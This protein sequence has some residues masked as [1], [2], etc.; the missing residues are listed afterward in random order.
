MED[1]ADKELQGHALSAIFYGQLLTPIAA[2]YFSDRYGGKKGI[3]VGLGVM[4]FCT[5]LT[6][7]FIRT[8]SGFVYAVRVI[9]GMMSGIATPSIY[10]ILGDWTAPKER[11]TLISI[12]LSAEALASVLA[13]LLSGDLCQYG[14]SVL[15]YIPG[16]AGVFITIF[17]D[18][19]AIRIDSRKKS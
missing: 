6:P 10:K 1:W 19:I 4:S 2:G 12:V 5:I 9:Q 3:Y 17:G 15:Y 13:P 16:L 18:I 7:L 8:H 14:W 11:A